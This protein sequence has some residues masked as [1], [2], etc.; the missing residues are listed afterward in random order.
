MLFKGRVSLF[1]I[2]VSWA[3]CWYQQNQNIGPSPALMLDYDT[4]IKKKA[5]P[6]T[7]DTEISLLQRLQYDF[8]GGGGT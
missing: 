6:V 4:G 5:S 2:S 7:T 8:N 3:E 1:W